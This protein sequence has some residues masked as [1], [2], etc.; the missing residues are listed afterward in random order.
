MQSNNN[1]TTT[2][3]KQTFTQ[4]LGLPKVQAGLMNSLS[5][6]K[7]VVKF[8]S[9]LASAVSTNPSLQDCDY[10]SLVSCGLLAHALELS[11]SPQLSFCYAVPFKQKEK[12]DKSGKIT[13]KACTKAQFILSYKGYLQLAIRSGYYTD[14][15]VIEVRQGEYLGR[16]SMT[17]KH[18][19]SFI[20]NEDERE[21]RPI[22]GYMAYFEQINGFKKVLFWS[23]EKMLKHADRY[24]PAFSYLGDD[25]K[26][27]FADYEKGNYPKAD[28]WKYSSFW[29]K[30]FDDMAFKTMIRQLISKW[31]IMSIEMQNAFNY[32]D[33]V[34]NNDYTD[35][36]NLSTPIEIDDNDFSDIA[37]GSSGNKR[38]DSMIDDETGEVV[39]TE[40]A[41]TED[42]ELLNGFFG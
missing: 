35:T 20:D 15:D 31:G 6:K 19:F 34:A 4:F 18:C 17:G 3:T 40:K 26:V 28:E 9:S 7:E 25:K 21:N 11:L 23:K 12:K 37:V 16:N 10:G 27:S 41:S 36:N 24:S 2:A 5:D 8:T 13:E 32:D 14:I 29:Y 42:E 30:S 22:V 38:I 33:T 39:E 1:L